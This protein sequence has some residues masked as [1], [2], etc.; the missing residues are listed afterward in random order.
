MEDKDKALLMQ[1]GIDPDAPTEEEKQAAQVLFT[2]IMT[3]T[4]IE[5]DV[6]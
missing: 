2:A 5:E 6:V 3:D 1:N 4:L